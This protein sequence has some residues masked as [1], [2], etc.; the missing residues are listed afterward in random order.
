[1]AA[2]LQDVVSVNLVLVGVGL[3][4]EPDELERF[5]NAVDLDLRLEVGLVTNVS[6]GITEPSR[7]LR[8]NRERIALDLSPS[9]S[10]I[11]REYPGEEDLASLAKVVMQAIDSTDLRGQLPRA[12]GCNIE[13]V[14]VQTSGQSTIQYIGER[15]FGSQSLGKAEWELVGGT[16]QLIFSD[17]IRRW[18]INVQPRPGDV[19]TSRVVL[20][21]NLHKDE[22]RFPTE[23]EIKDS[24]EE[25][26]NEAKEFMNR[27]DESKA[28]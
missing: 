28:L 13:L 5:R 11:A 19:D 22:Q 4:N 6:S 12:F 15:L 7:T 18:T 2:T 20:A 10:S 17:G 1:M 16:G 25:A 23:G 8:L 21:L 14:F 27:L 9:R 3:L 24:L 26:W